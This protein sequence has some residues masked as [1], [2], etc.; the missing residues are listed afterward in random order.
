MRK[1]QL[2]LTNCLSKD[3]LKDWQDKRTNAGSCLT[4]GERFP[5]SLKPQLILA[6]LFDLIPKP[7]GLF[8]L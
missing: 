8:K 6:Q 2:E 7:S 3:D 1:D 4:S 5:R